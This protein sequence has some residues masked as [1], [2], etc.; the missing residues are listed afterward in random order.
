MNLEEKQL[1]KEYV[2]RGKIINVRK[3]VVG[4]K[5]FQLIIDNLFPHKHIIKILKINTRCYF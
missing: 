5:T 2:Y 3:K 4:K 1:S